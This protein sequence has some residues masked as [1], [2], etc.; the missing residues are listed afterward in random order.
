MLFRKIEETPAALQDVFG[1]LVHQGTF[2]GIRV[3]I[4][5]H[6]ERSE[7]SNELLGMNGAE[8]RGGRGD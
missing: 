4:G 8:V 6:I 1:P 2:R 5:A 3:S 7:I